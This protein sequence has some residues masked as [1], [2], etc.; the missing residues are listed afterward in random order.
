MPDLDSRYSLVQ[1]RSAC[2]AYTTQKKRFVAV[3]SAAL[4]VKTGLLYRMRTLS[5]GKFTTRLSYCE[6]VIFVFFIESGGACPLGM[7]EGRARVRFLAACIAILCFLPT[8]HALVTRE[9]GDQVI[10][11]SSCEKNKP[12][13]AQSRLAPTARTV[14]WEVSSNG[15]PPGGSRT[16]CAPRCF[17]L[18]EPLFFAAAA[19]SVLGRERNF[20]ASKSSL[21]PPCI[22]LQTGGLR[23][24][25]AL[26]CVGPSMKLYVFFIS[27]HFLSFTLCRLMRA[28][29]PV[30][31]T[32]GKTFM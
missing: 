15:Q 20:P 11:T 12:R 5:S 26:R 2:G 8:P 14:V 13:V 29:L 27:L 24:C 18:G 23:P 17:S 19:P 30:I 9:G 7:V 10:A 28:F 1:K 16:H 22:F 3:L 32:A 31:Y 25:T 4:Q 21:S 6:D